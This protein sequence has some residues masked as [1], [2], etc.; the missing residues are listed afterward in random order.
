M[1]HTEDRLGHAARHQPHQQQTDQR[2]EQAEA[3]FDQC[4][5]GIAR[6]QLLLE[7]FGAADQ[8]FLRHI[9]QHAP[10]RPVGNRLERRQHFQL[11]VAVQAAHASARGEQ[12]QQLAAAG[13]IHRIQALAEFAGIRA[14]TGEQAGG[15]DNTDGGLAVIQLAAGV[16]ADRLQAVEIDVDRQRGDDFAVDLQREDDAGHQHFVAVDDIEVRLDHARFE[17][18]ARAGE[19]GVGGL[20]AGA[21]AG[22]AHV[23]FRQRHRGDFARGRLRPVQGKTA[24]V[25]AAQFSLIGE[26]FVLA[27]QRVGFEHQRQAEQVRVGLQ[28]GFDLTGH[29]LAQIEGIEKTLLGLLTQKQYLPREAVAV[30]IGVHELLTNAGGLHFTLRLDP[31]LRRLGEHLHARGLDQ[32]RAVFHAIQ[33]KTDQQGHDTGQAEAGEQGDFPLDGKLSERHGKHPYPINI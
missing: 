27:V 24:L 11:A 31:R 19:P 15:A 8:D 33:R 28:R 13:L 21:G 9:E 7:R 20:T 30:L 22:V 26:Q 5:R 3:Q 1:R 4:A 25:V 14:V 16:L 6:I 2:G 17:R 18:G 10:R 32:R 23:A 29:V 12:A